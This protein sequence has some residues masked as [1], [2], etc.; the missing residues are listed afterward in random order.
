MVSNRV[1]TVRLVN[2]AVFEAK[3][4]HDIG[5][6]LR[7]IKDGGLGFS[8]TADFSADSCGF[9][10]FAEDPSQVSLVAALVVADPVLHALLQVVL[11]LC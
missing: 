3:G 7:V 8:S 9:E 2:N 6:A 1:L 11:L 10:A 4:V 5:V